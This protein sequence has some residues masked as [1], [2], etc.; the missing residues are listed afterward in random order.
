MYPEIIEVNSTEL[1]NRK[2]SFCPRGS[3]Y[4]NLNRNLS[5]K[6]ALILYDKLLEFDYKGNFHIT[7]SG[8]P[9]LNPNFV[10]IVK[11]FR[12][13]NN[14]KIKMTTNG[15]YIGKKDF[16]YFKYFDEI[17]ISIYDGD[18]R[19]DEVRKLTDGYNVDIRK[20]YINEPMF[21]N[22][23]GW[24]PVSNLKD[25][26]CYIPFYRLHIDWN[27]D[28]RL[29]CHDWK[30]KKVLGNLRF[31]TLEN[32]WM[33]YFE[34][35]RKELISNNRKNLSPCNKCNVN[36]VENIYTKTP[37]G[38]KHFNFF[39]NYYEGKNKRNF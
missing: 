9:T 24:F 28:I 30:E 25:K 6:D 8:E 4:P 34:E 38:L 21:N 15:D 37:D 16:S 32:V 5:M 23:G 10:D 12:Q 19:Y 14:L 18:E 35:V 39:R 33:D 17:R 22:C 27:L 13:N 11:L 36:G 31:D 1:C 2:C 20:Q 29:C 7:G 3:G 26:T